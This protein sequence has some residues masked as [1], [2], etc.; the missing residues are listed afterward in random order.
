MSQRFTNRATRCYTRVSADMLPFII[1][2]RVE[3]A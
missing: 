3:R 1:M 2:N